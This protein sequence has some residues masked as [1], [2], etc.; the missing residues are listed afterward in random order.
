MGSA[1]MLGQFPLPVSHSEA[2]MT[3]ILQGF[4]VYSGVQSPAAHNQRARRNGYWSPGVPSCHT[5]CSQVIS[6]CLTIYP[7][8]TK[9]PYFGW[10]LTQSDCLWIH[11][12]LCLGVQ[13]RKEAGSASVLGA[14]LRNQT[15]NI[16]PEIY[17]LEGKHPQNLAHRLHCLP[18]S[19]T[20]WLTLLAPV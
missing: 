9:I 11:P 18:L 3:E 6:Q 2:A 19:L 12:L 1:R 7:V 17:I 15:D 4:T 16:A 13:I 5:V 8:N 10:L 20:N 14:L